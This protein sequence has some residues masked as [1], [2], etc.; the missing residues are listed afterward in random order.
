MGRLNRLRVTHVVLSL[1]CGGL[2]RIVVALVR[3]GLRLGQEVSVVCLESRGAL[4]ADVESLNVPLVC[5]NKQPGLKLRLLPHLVHVL[6]EL[7]PDVLHTHQTG[8]LFYSGP[9][10]RWASVPVVVHTE[11]GNHFRHP[12]SNFMA[13]LRKSCLWWFA[14]RHAARFFCVTK[15]IAAELAPRR[16]I[17][18]HKLEFLPNGI[19]ASTFAEPIDREAMRRSLGFPSNAPV[20]GT[21]GRLDEIKQQDVLIRAFAG[22]RKEYPS[23]RL[24]VVGDG[25]MRDSLQQLAN[26]LNLNGMVHFAGYQPQPERYLHAMDVFA[27]T[28]RI[29]GMPLAILEAWGAG[30]PVVAS[31]VGGIPDLIEHGC[32]GLLFPGGDEARLAALICELIREPEQAHSLGEAGRQAVMTRYNVQRMACDYQDHYRRLLGRAETE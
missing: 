31:A 23:A 28:S 4:A 9:A 14:G 5:L 2:E 10:A 17:P 21:V 13:R 30:L 8:A 24:L 19:D 25:P 1:D 16:L 20:I 27:L 18:Q 32:N 26:E 29:E 7:R 15:D 11:H 3:E 22:V 12:E 6:R